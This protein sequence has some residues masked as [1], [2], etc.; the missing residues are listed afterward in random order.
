MLI[1]KN[2]KVYEVT[3]KEFSKAD[4]DEE[5]KMIDEEKDM[6]QNEIDRLNKRLTKWNEKK[7]FLNKK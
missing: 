4:I 5:I 2:G 3:E 7:D 1:V 6:H